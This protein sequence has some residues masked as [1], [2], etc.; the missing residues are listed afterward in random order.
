MAMKETRS[1]EVAPGTDEATIQEWRSFGWELVGAPQVVRTSDSQ[2]FTGQD[3]DGTEHYTTTKGV[4]YIKLTFERDPA[5]PNYNELKSLE[6]EYRS[7]KDPYYPEAPRFITKLWLILIGVGLLAY[8][9]PGI[10]LLV[11]HIILHVKKSKEYNEDYATYTRKSAEVR[12][13]REEILTKAQAL[14]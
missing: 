9:I 3:S 12:S 4:H 13:Q 14:V 7:I 1:F 6:G 11:I 2:V 8:V 10:I 5:R